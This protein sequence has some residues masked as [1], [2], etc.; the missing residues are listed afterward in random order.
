MSD[1]PRPVIDTLGV[2]VEIGD[3]VRVT[4]WGAPV[5]LT[6]T[7]RLATVAGFSRTGNIV[8]DEGTDEPDP[9]ARGRSVRPGYLAVQRRDGQ[10]GHEGNRSDA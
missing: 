2:P 10:P 6:D 3:T 9:I 4:S 5:R 7:G 1:H 8:L